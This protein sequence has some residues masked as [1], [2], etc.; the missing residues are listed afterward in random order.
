MGLGTAP[1][2]LA[3]SALPGKTCQTVTYLGACLERNIIARALI[4]APVS[5]L[6]VW[7]K[8]F[9]K[10]TDGKVV[11]LLFHGNNVRERNKNL[12]S[13]RRRGG[14]CVTSYGLAASQYT[15]LRSRASTSTNASPVSSTH[16]RCAL[17]ALCCSTARTRSTSGLPL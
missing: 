2:P 15:A 13:V 5:V 3:L 16:T 10:F 4:V 6:G 8:E 12:A 9:A 14:V 11:P 1:L 7:L 17:V